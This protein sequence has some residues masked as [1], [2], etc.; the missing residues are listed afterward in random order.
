[1]VRISIQI[2]VTKILHIVLSV[3][4]EQ[5]LDFDF[6]MDIRF[7]YFLLYSHSSGPDRGRLSTLFFLHLGG[8]ADGHAAWLR[9]AEETPGKNQDAPF[10]DY[11]RVFFLTD[12]GNV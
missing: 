4:T 5:M 10:C 11:K 2:N 1:M 6:K 8:S 9:Y 12:T 3:L 7:C